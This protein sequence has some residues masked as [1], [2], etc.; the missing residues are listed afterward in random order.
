MP[1]FVDLRG[2]FCLVVGGGP[3]AF[4]KAKR[5]A[6]A[7][8]KLLVISPEVCDEL[9]RLEKR[10]GVHINRCNFSK[11]WFEA[12]KSFFLVAA[13]TNNKALNKEITDLCRKKGILV[14]SATNPEKGDVFFGAEAGTRKLRVAVSTAGQ[15]PLAAALFA[16]AIEKELPEETDEFIEKLTKIRV[17]GGVK[18]AKPAASVRLE[19]EQSDLFEEIKTDGGRAAL[20][21]IKKAMAKN[22]GKPGNK[23]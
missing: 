11:K 17:K 6:D 1:L 10:P 2:K 18:A 15:S 22:V 12:L 14:N 20:N 4:R 23:Q 19:M 8:A 3:V 9:A 13:C 16:R 21:L 5:L 7:G